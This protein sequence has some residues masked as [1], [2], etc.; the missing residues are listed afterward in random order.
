MRCLDA[1]ILLKSL[2]K[3]DLSDSKRSETIEHYKCLL[4]ST[5]GR[6]RSDTQPGVDLLPSV[7]GTGVS[8]PAPTL[9]LLVDVFG[10]SAKDV[11]AIR[12]GRIRQHRKGLAGL[13][14]DPLSEPRDSKNQIG[15]A[16]EREQLAWFAKAM[17]DA[18]MAQPR[19]AIASLLAQLLQLRHTTS[20]DP[21]NAN[22]LAFVKRVEDQGASMSS[23]SVSWYLK[24]ETEQSLS[25]PTE[26][27]LLS[28]K[29]AAH[30]TLS[31]AISHFKR[32][33]QALENH[34]FLVKSGPN[35]GNIK[36]S[37]E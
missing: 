5:E 26:A 15:N 3:D 22:E 33:D 37:R 21:L 7:P 31:A 9:A 13:G 16:H 27:Q 36:R 1:H 8:R 32:L 17:A 24:W 20:R 34:G 28:D 25:A 4:P 6:L 30:Y 14:V 18:K 10:V 2:Y 12:I 35:K 23:L 11:E 29:R 19:D